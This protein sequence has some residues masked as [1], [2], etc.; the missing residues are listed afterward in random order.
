MKTRSMATMVM[1][2]A[3]GSVMSLTADAATHDMAGMSH[4]QMTMAS[5]PHHVLAMAYH[6][7][8]SVFATAL[9][10][11]TAH[12]ASVNVDFARA[13]VTELRRSFDQ[14]SLHHQAHLGTMT[15]AMR[16]QMSGMMQDMEMHRTELNAQI[17]ALE[18][19]VQMPTPDAKTV[20][21][22]ATG[23]NTHL[24]AMTKMMQAGHGKK[25]KMKM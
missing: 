17:T 10:E 21:K 3:L 2:L 12:A 25:T 18:H 14:M 20:Y 15:A 1:A 22:M 19:E 24:D 11:Q 9:Q 23:V 8:M 16:T 7:N 13:A 6:R 5:E 4:M